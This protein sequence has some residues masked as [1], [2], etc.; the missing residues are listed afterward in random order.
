MHKVF[1]KVSSQVLRCKLEPSF[2]QLLIYLYIMMDVSVGQM[3]YF[4]TE[5]FK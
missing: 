2:S 1:L 4:I 3:I 5:M